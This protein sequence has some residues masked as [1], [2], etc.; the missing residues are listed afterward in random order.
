MAAMTSIYHSHIPQVHIL[1]FLRTSRRLVHPWRLLQWKSLTDFC[2][3]RKFVCQQVRRQHVPVW[4]W[5][6]PSQV[7]GIIDLNWPPLLC[8]RRAGAS[9]LFSPLRCLP[10]VSM[11]IDLDYW[12][13]FNMTLWL[14]HAKML[15]SV[16][17]WR[18]RWTTRLR[19]SK[20]ALLGGEAIPP[21]RDGRNSFI[22]LSPLLLSW[23]LS[24]MHIIRF[25]LCSA[26]YSRRAFEGCFQCLHPL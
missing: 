5:I 26:A 16:L 17:I 1:Y 21:S 7:S 2:K 20:H 9:A 10:S 12:H 8:F 18:W 14:S 15:E 23:T 11:P 13:Q 24:P 22:N 4:Y 25:N 6:A 3:K 19:R